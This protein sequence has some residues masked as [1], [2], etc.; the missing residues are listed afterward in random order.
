M[1]FVSISGKAIITIFL[2]HL[3]MPTIKW[4]K[5]IPIYIIIPAHVYQYDDKNFNKDKY[6]TKF[7]L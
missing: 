4:N 7:Y 5:I 2:I 1:S 6:Y 3:A